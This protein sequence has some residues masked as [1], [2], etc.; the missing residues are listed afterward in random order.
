MSFS[1]LKNNEILF[2]RKGR[3]W[4]L[5]GFKLGEFSEPS[6][7]TMYLTIALKNTDMCNAFIKGLKETGYSESDIIIDGNIVGLIFD[8]PHTHQPITRI[9]E[10]DWIIQR[11]MNCYVISIGNNRS[12]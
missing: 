8:E 9:E 10:T 7:L 6:Q 3:H 1:L 12:V 11:K 5:T 2:N 4:W